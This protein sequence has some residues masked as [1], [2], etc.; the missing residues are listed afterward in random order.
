MIFEWGNSEADKDAGAPRGGFAFEAGGR[1]E[2]EK[3]VSAIEEALAFNVVPR[4]ALIGRFEFGRGGFAPWSRCFFR[5]TISRVK[6]A[7]TFRNR[8]YFRGSSA[9]FSLTEAGEKSERMS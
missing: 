8:V 6:R 3:V 1:F 9:S 7:K 2:I 4:A 5:F